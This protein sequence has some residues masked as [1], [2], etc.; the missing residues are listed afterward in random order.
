MIQKEWCWILS[1]FNK[2]LSSLWWALHTESNPKSLN[3]KKKQ[4]RCLLWNFLTASL[5]ASSASFPAPA[6]FSS[7]PPIKPGTVPKWITDT[8][9]TTGWS[10]RK[11]KSWGREVTAREAKPLEKSSGDQLRAFTQSWSGHEA[12]GRYSCYFLICLT[13][14]KKT[15]TLIWTSSRHATIWLGVFF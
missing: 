12:S 3:R 14:E 11:E 5:L 7:G 15:W 13:S 6:L 9:R 4:N 8:G 1:A 10:S 2:G